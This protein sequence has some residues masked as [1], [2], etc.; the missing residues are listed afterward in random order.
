ME[1]MFPNKDGWL[2]VETVSDSGERV[3][4]F[5]GVLE[6]SSPEARKAWREDLRAAV[7]AHK[8]TGGTTVICRMV[9]LFQGRVSVSL[10]RGLAA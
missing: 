7:R 10:P 9:P 5:H 3:T 2:S 6:V 8:A 4:V 1:R